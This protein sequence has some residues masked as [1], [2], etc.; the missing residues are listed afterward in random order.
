MVPSASQSSHRDARRR[1]ATYANARAR[2]G[3]RARARLGVRRDGGASARGS[4]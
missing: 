1:A 4:G 3:A 2:V